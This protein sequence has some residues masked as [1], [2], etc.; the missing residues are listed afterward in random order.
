VTSFPFKDQILAVHFGITVVLAILSAIY[1]IPFIYTRSQKIQ[2]LVSI[3][4]S[5][6]IAAVSFYIW[7]LFLI[8]ANQEIPENSLLTFSMVTLCLGA[9]LFIAIVIRFSILLGKGKYRKGSKRDE[10]R[11][12]FE[13]KTYFPAIIIGSTGL[14]FIIQFVV[15][16]F[17]L[18][19]IEDVMLIFIC[20][21][22]FYTMIFVLP[23]QL[24]ILYCK[25]RF[26]SF[27]FNKRGSLYNEE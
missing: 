27:N 15:R 24:V 23:E 4:V 20:F 18:A 11:A 14:V 10:L 26:K 8:G 7:G 12:K 19:D 3:L 6:N 22:L 21:T 13:T 25:F 5:Q 16:T 17:N 9:L 2:Y 1:A